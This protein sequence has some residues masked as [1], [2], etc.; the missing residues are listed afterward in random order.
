MLKLDRNHLASTFN[1]T[2]STKDNK[3]L[4]LNQMRILY[5]FVLLWFVIQVQTNKNTNVKWRRKVEEV[6]E[7]YRCDAVKK[8]CWIYL[9]ISIL[10]VEWRASGRAISL[11]ITLEYHDKGIYRV[12]K[13]KKI[14][15]FVCLFST[16]EPYIFCIPISDMSFSSV[17]YRH[18]S[19]VCL[20]KVMSSVSFNHV[21]IYVIVYWPN[22]KGAR[23]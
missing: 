17:I 16:C 9:Y 18:S 5:D 21:L 10:I 11:C 6:E 15:R 8:S 19:I 7:R 2:I 23:S 4:T 22:I 1:N 14:N 20:N 12:Y 3:L 13:G